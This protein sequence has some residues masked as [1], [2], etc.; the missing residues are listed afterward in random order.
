MVALLK[1]G[2]DET[3]Q[4]CHYVGNAGKYMKGKG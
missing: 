3:V 1:V 4:F 2:F